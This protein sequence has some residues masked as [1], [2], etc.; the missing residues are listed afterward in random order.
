MSAPWSSGEGGIG[1][2]GGASREKETLVWAAGG[3]GWDDERGGA[4]LGGRALISDVEGGDAG[5][6]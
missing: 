1:G 4:A 6:V 2:S 5:D 3:C